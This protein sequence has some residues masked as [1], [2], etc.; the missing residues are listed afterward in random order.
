MIASASA[1][2]NRGR[3]RDLVSAA[4]EISFVVISSCLQRVIYVVEGRTTEQTLAT[5]SFL[6]QAVSARVEEP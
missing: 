2:S 3:F 6:V 5:S 4:L 1:A